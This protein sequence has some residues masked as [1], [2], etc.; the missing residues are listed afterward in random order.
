MGHRGPSCAQ[1]APELNPSGVTAPTRLPGRRRIASAQQVGK[2]LHEAVSDVLRTDSDPQPVRP[3]PGE[4]VSATDRKSLSTKGFAE[5][6]AIRDMHEHERRPRHAV[7]RKSAD[8]A[9]SVKEMDTLPFDVERSLSR[10]RH[11]PLVA[12]GN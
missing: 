11:G 6:G 5:Y 3:E 12:A 10:F 1:S 9:Q 8:C 7:R 2:H 4:R